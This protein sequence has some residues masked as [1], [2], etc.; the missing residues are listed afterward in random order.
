MSILIA[1]GLASFVFVALFTWRAYT[2]APGPGQSPRS[3]IAEA[4]VN[5]AVGFGINFV[6]NFLI[7]P[8]IGAHPTAA[9]N[10]WMGWIYTAVSIVRQYA[11]RRWF[12]AHLVALSRRLA[13]EGGS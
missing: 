5:I 12:N 2:R 7:L 8:L 10:F 4:W 13:G 11:I 1:F 9:Q 3:A 6:A